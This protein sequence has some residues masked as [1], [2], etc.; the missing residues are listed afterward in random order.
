VT[1]TVKNK[2]G[3]PLPGQVVK[4]SSD[5]NLAAFS[6]PSALT[7]AEGVA[8]VILSPAVSTSTGADL[9]KAT[10]KYIDKDYSASTGFQLTATN[11]TIASFVSDVTDKLS[12]YG[13]AN[14]TVTLAGTSANSPVNLVLTSSC[15]SAGKG[16][17]T[18]ASQTTSTGRATFTFRDG[19]CGAVASTENLQVSVTGTGLTQSL[20]VPVSSPAVASIG[21]V[22][23]TPSKIFLRGSGYVENSNV[24]FQVRDSNNNGIPEQLVDLEPNVLVGGLTL[25]GGS[26]KV[27]KKTDKDGNV[28]VRINSGT[29]PTPVRIKASY[30]PTGSSVPISTVS[31]SL[32]IA[33]G[34]PSQLN[35][36]FSQGTQ[37]IEGYSIQG[38]KNT[39]T[40]IA[41]DRMGNQV[42]DGTAINFV[43]EGGQVEATKQTALDVNGI[44]TATANFA[45]ASPVPQDGR[46]TVVA[47]ALGEKSFLDTDGDNVFTD[48]K[49]EFQ[50]LGDIYID[51]KFDA[52][53]F[54][55][56]DQF[57]SVSLPDEVKGACLDAKNDLMKIPGASIP[58]RPDTCSGKW[59]R[60]YVRRAVQTILSTSG[61]RPLWGTQRPG[62]AVGQAGVCSAGTDLILGYVDNKAI[63]ATFYPVA[64][65]ELYDMSGSGFIS[66]TAGDANPIAYNPMAAGT[67]VSASGTEG[68][69][70]S[71]VG[72]SPVPNTAS[73]SG[74]GLSYKFDLLKAVEGTITISFASPSGLTTNSSIFVSTKS[75]SGGLATCKP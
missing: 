16:T 24:I 19:G 23:S 8:T 29:V 70:V 74:V 44:A 4:F 42:P 39:Y 15:T 3:T 26:A 52:L 38:T 53:F 73:P 72:G 66:F 55:D 17:L 59:G 69:T 46:I 13:Q 51:R 54:K 65:S 33:V 71:V 7:S 20:S 67:L 1:V 9:V 40:I 45:S 25:D 34:L 10:V 63:V 14:L 75:P 22:S 49:E 50:D 68:L 27:T 5:A 6:A 57:I 61:A 62:Q 31:S 35:F 47:Y 11:V 41:S 2:A 21:F 37:N 30:L 48:G 18:P 28:I 58:S 64:G 32:A 60:A 56:E 43:T 12:S 36:S